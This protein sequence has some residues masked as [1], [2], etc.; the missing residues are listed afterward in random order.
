MNN[1]QLLHKFFMDY[2][3][4]LYAGA[5]SNMF[6]RACGLCGNIYYFGEM[7]G[8]RRMEMR[9]HLQRRFEE[10]GMSPRLPFNDDIYDFEIESD[11]HNCHRNINRNI[12]VYS[13]IEKYND[14]LSRH[15]EIDV[16]V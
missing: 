1:D 16:R 4:W 10:Q 3:A 7:P 5:K 12:W 6:N 14:D 2:L 13:Q 11:N 8:H 9:K 15:H